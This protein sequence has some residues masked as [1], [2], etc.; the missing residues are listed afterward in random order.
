MLSCSFIERL[1]F[2]PQCTDLCSPHYTALHI[3]IFYVRIWVFDFGCTLYNI[4]SQCTAEL[5]RHS[6][7]FF[8]S[9]HTVKGG[10]SLFYMLLGSLATFSKMSTLAKSYSVELAL[11][12]LNILSIPKSTRVIHILLSTKLNITQH[13][14]ALEVP[15]VLDVISDLNWT[16]KLERIHVIKSESLARFTTLS[17]FLAHQQIE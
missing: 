4:L 12:H 7:L 14:K 3:P 6:N 17:V 16:C 1:F 2:S 5:V 9:P 15:N 13:W 8:Y 11:L 10:I